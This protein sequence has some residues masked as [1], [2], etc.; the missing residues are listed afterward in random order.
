M[1]QDWKLKLRYG[2]M[3]TPFTHYTTLADGV[4]NELTEGFQ[5]PKGKV[6]MAMKNWASSTVES[7]DMIREIGKQ[8]GFEGTGKIEGYETDPKEPPTDKP[9]GYDIHFTPYDE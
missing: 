8:S 7:A 3:T 4:V 2:K 6:W 1:E 9:R 5:C